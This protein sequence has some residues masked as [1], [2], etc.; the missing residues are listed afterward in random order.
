MSVNVIYLIINRELS[1]FSSD[2]PYSR[3]M[4]IAVIVYIACL[5]HV[6][7]L[8][9]RSKKNIS[10]AIHVQSTVTSSEIN[11]YSTK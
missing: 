4:C 2:I 3:C 9:M 8:C 6:R 7:T 1:Q 5:Q 10:G 11:M